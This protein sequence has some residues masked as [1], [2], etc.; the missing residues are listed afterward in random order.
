LR[1]GDE[2]LAVDHDSGLFGRATDWP[3]GGHSTSLPRHR[4]QKQLSQMW[5]AAG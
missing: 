2:A 1:R 5:S 3:R 4:R